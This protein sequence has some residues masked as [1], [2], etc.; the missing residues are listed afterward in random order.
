MARKS[1]TAVLKRQRELKKAE[2]AAA[3]R[4]KR[5]AREGVPAERSVA[6]YD[7]LAGYGLVDRDREDDRDH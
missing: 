6:T 2:K 7:D 1:K 3:K 4:E 5:A